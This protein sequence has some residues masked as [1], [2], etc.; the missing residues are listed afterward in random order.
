MNDTACTGCG[1]ELAPG[2]KFCRSCGQATS[3]PVATAK[4]E[5]CGHVSPSD[6]SFCRSCG[7]RFPNHS[8]RP[9]GESSTIRQPLPSAPAAAQGGGRPAAPPPAAFPPPP[10]SPPSSGD[11]NTTL[12][13]VAAVLALVAA[14]VGGVLLARRGSSHRPSAVGV[15]HET[16]TTTITGGGV[17]KPTAQAGA[18][19]TQVSETSASPRAGAT[20]FHVPSGHVTCEVTYDSARCTVS[21]T[22]E[23]F[24]LPNNTVAYTQPGQALSPQSATLVEYGDSVTAGVVTCHVPRSNE[25]HGISCEN[26]STG[27][28]FEASQVGPR[29]RLF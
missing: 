9:Q 20:V 22:R 16:T 2:A 27:H 18:T 11:R 23:T 6:S 1:G 28:G 13:V 17:P 4:C 12:L 19:A 24:V 21:P 29:T 14:G 3:E 26:T 7:T 25:H 15:S 10:P 8:G 5:T